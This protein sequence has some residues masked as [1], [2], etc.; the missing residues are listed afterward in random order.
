VLSRAAGRRLITLYV[1]GRKSG[2]RYS[3]PVAYTRDGDT[4][5]V[6]T[7]FAWARNL[8]TGEPVHGREAAVQRPDGSHVIAMVHIEPLKDASG[9]LLGAIDI[10]RGAKVS[11]ARFYYL[12]GAGADL[13]FALVNMANVVG[14]LLM[15]SVRYRGGFAQFFRTLATFG[16]PVV[17]LINL[18]ILLAT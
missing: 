10:D 6:G 13:E 4:L 8:R 1:V 7:P 11:G 18:V 2:K 14:T 17:V 9:R 5:V 12:T 16:T 3:V 15:E